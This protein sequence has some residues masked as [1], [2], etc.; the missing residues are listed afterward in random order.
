MRAEAHIDVNAPATAVWEAF[1]DPLRAIHVLH[2]VTRWEQLTPDPPGLGTRYRMLMRIRAVE[3]GGVIEVVEWDPARDMA[4]TSVT[5][6]D[7]RGRLRLRERVPGRTHVELRFAGGVAGAGIGGWLAERLAQPD[8]ARSLRASLVLLKQHVEYE[9][10][11]RAAARRRE[12][13]LHGA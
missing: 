7:Q 5:G 8:V 11:R 3:A 10:R 1:S 6:I 4:W 9:E 13:A 2:H 12:A